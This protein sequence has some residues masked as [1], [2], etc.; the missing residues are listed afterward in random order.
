[1]YLERKNKRT[2]TIT[3]REAGQDAA[4]A[5]DISLSSAE[6]LGGL[7]HTYTKVDRQAPKG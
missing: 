6:V 5:G 4:P 7:Y 2:V 3:F 1:M